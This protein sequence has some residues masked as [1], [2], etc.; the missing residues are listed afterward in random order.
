MPQDQYLRLWQ[1]ERA[2]IRQR[3]LL[4]AVC[5][6]ACLVAAGLV[7]G[8]AVLAVVGASPD[9]ARDAL[10]PAAF[11]LMGLGGAGWAVVT[12]CHRDVAEHHRRAAQLQRTLPLPVDVQLQ[13]L[14]PPGTIRF[15]QP[16]QRP[17]SGHGLLTSLYFIHWGV[18]L[19]GLIA[20]F[21]STAS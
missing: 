8:L 14:P 16:G 19:S 1:E 4:A 18:L 17:Q 10:L 15:Q 7:L 6:A 12:M 21:V 2:D 9:D 13:E 3:L 20:L 5:S 11:T